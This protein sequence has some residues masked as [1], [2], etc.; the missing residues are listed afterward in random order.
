MPFK[1]GNIP[2]NNGKIGVRCGVKKGNIPWNKD[3]K[4][5]NA[6][7]NNPHWKGGEILKRC[8]F[9]KK[10]FMSEPS[11]KRKYCCRKCKDLAHRNFIPWNTGK[12]GIYSKEYREKL[13]I[14]AKNKILE[15]N[16]NWRGGKSFEP[17]PLGWNK[18]FK[19]QIRYRDG[20]KCQICGVPEVECKSKLHIHHIDYDK[21]NIKEDNLISLCNKCHLKTNGKRECWITLFAQRNMA[22]MGG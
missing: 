8:L 4:G 21:K 16:P 19:E 15:K 2:W 14:S 20:Y 7:K 17:Y 9:C 5:F 3:L 6:G 10:E 12:K 18:T 1:K 22:G 11:T 13:S